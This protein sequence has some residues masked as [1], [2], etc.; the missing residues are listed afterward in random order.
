MFC[1]S[2]TLCI[3]SK[4]LLLRPL[5]GYFDTAVSIDAI[6]TLAT[7]DTCDIFCS[8][9]F[10]L[11]RLALRGLCY[12]SYFLFVQ[13]SLSIADFI[14]Y[15]SIHSVLLSFAVRSDHHLSTHMPSY[16]CCT[17][18]HCN[19]FSLFFCYSLLPYYS[20]VS[21]QYSAISLYQELQLIHYHVKKSMLG[22]YHDFYRRP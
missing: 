19:R 4:V 21:R 6:D 13:K 18:G 22:R 1:C 14:C 10:V 15:F 11:Y 12:S 5:V 17:F 7:S 2:D 20:P 9:L 16:C 8:H 3:W